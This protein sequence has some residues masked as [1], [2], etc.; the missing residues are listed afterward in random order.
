[1]FTNCIPQLE[2]YKAVLKMRLFIINNFIA[3]IFALSY[4]SIA[5]AAVQSCIN[6]YCLL[7]AHVCNQQDV[8][9]WEVV[10]QETE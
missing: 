8:D 3:I 10:T 1:M 2:K 9:L 4:L 7:Y 6:H 5:Q